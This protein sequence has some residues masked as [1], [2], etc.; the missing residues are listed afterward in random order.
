MIRVH[1]TKKLLA[2]LPLD[3]SGRLLSKHRGGEAANDSPETWL[4]GWHANLVTLQRRQCVLFA[5]DATRFPVFIPCLTKRD[6]AELDSWFGDVFMNTLLKLG[7]TNQQMNAASSALG[8][9]VFDSDCN[10]S[11]QGSMNQMVQ[12]LDHSLW[13]NNAKVEDLPIYSTSASLAHRPCGVKGAKDWVWPDK[14][15]LALIDSQ[16]SGL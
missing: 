5:H 9:L 8:P 1:S 10:R 7:A 16:S 15:M 4:S 13:Y 6:F 3:D 11:V 12:D 14:A 2:K